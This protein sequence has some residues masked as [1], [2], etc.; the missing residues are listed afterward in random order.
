MERFVKGD[1]VVLDFPFSNLLDVKRRPTMIVKIPKGK[2]V[3]VSQIT[4]TSQES[5]MEIKILRKD[6]E[7]GGLK[8]DSYLRLDKIFSIEKSLIKYKAGTLK[9]EKFKEILDKICSFLKN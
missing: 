9:E 8:V 6:F 1:I 3:I 4:G 2:D 5:S 7:V